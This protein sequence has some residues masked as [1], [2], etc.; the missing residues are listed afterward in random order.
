MAN[1]NRMVVIVYTQMLGDDSPFVFPEQWARVALD[2][3]LDNP[4][5]P[6]RIGRW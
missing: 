6:L 5:L 1:I 3:L 2:A 4:I